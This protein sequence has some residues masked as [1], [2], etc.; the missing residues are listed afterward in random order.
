[1]NRRNLLSAIV[2]AGVPVVTAATGLA[3]QEGPESH[4]V[5]RTE[6]ERATADRAEA[7][8][9][10]RQ[11]I[12]SVLEHPE[13]RRTAGEHGIDITR[14]TDAVTTLEGEALARAFDQAQKVEAA[15]AG[16]DQIVISSTLVIIVLLVLIL[17]AVS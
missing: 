2:L 7:A 16:G 9:A 11:A 12:R 8:Q 6:L 4:V 17:I 1:M 3:A 10:R 14:A 13:V 5:E 15:L